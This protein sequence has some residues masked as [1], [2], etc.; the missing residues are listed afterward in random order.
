MVAP[1]A[2]TRTIADG[3]YFRIDH[4][5]E[6]DMCLMTRTP[7]AFETIDALD[8]A[9]DDACAALD[10]LGR[11]DRRLLVDMR[12][13]QGR[14]DEA[15]EVAMRRHR[16]RVLAG[17]ERVAILVRSAV[18]VLQL[19]RHVREDGGADAVIGSDLGAILR[20]LGVA[21]GSLELRDVG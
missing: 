6:A 3:R 4:D 17:F 5:P 7:A 16:P 19:S 12:A 20:E 15:F 13:V 8:R 9:F 10:R 11:A 2:W 1:M 21:A 18:G 14:N